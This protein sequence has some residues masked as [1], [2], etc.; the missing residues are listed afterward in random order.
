MLGEY[1]YDLNFGLGLV[2]QF[3]LE[4]RDIIKKVKKLEVSRKSG[5]VVTLRLCRRFAYTPL[6][7]KYDNGPI[8]ATTRRRSRSRANMLG[9]HALS[10]YH[11]TDTHVSFP[12]Q[13]GYRSFSALCFFEWA[14]IEKRSS[15]PPLLALH[16]LC[17]WPCPR[18]Q[19]ISHPDVTVDTINSKELTRDAQF[20]D[21][22]PHN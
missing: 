4:D 18:R 8:L 3:S 15:V 1:E 17:L 6:P 12:F 13:Y 16:H 22:L 5:R 20:N 19:R 2:D 21:S 11:H 9:T 14:V 10:F 7:M